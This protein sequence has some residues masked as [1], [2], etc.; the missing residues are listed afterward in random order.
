MEFKIRPFTESDVSGINEIRR[1]DG[2]IETIPT[3]SSE[4]E[5]F[6]SELFKGYDA[7]DPSF[8]AVAFRNGVEVIAGHAILHTNKKARTRH[9]A[10]IAIIVRTDCQDMGIGR[11]LLTRLLKIADEDL[12]LVRVE[13]EVAANNPRAIHLYE[14]LGFVREGLCR[15]TFVQQG[16]YGDT[17]MMGRYNFH[18]GAF[19]ED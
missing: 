11:A 8:T 15:Y 18:K 17:I 9:A 1:M 3:L 19:A 16:R 5:S 6:T 12:M 10:S 2:V 7:G 4:S 13:L 14:S